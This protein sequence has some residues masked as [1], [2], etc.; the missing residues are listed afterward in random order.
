M[1][2]NNRREFLKKSLLMGA[3]ITLISELAKS[4]VNEAASINKAVAIDISAVKG[5]DYFNCTITAIEKLGGIS[6]FVPKGS[7]VGLLHNA[8]NWWA[9]PG[10]HTNT[11]VVLATIKLLNDAGVKEIIWLVDPADDFY[12]RSSRSDQFSSLTKAIKSKSGEYKDTDIP[13]GVS[14]K[15]AK[16]L[17]D[18]F[19]CDVFINIPITKHHAG[20]DMSNNLKNFMGNCKGETNKFFHSS[21]DEFLSQCIADVNLIR[22]PDLCICD[23]TEVLKTNGPAGPGEIIKPQTVYAGTDPVAMDA[24]GSTLLGSQPGNIRSV[25]LANKHGLGEMELSKVNVLET[26]I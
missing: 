13:K 25:V 7:K 8:P 2:E 6:K 24:Y 9:R 23:A 19:D 16:I 1:S 10:S 12:K 26:V 11:D 5:S 15:S 4:S 20:V 18:L 14:L 22:K 17:K 21:T 3:G